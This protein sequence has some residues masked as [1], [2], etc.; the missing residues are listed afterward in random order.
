MR[1]AVLASGR[2]SNLEALLRHARSGLLEAGVGLLVTDRPGAPCVQ[3]AREGGVPAVVELPPGKD[4]AAY[5][6][7]LAAV[8]LGDAPDLVVL[9]GFMRILGPRVLG[10]FPHKIVNVHPS[11]LPAFKGANAVRSALR[12]GARVTGCTTHF[13]TADL[14]GGPGIL[15]AAVAVRPEDDED[16]LRS[17]IQALEH[18]VLPRTVQLAAEGRLRVEDGRVHVA[19]GPS[20][21][22]RVEPVAGAL[23]PDGF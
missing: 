19:P 4:A 7:A 16:S 18:Q 14:D 1:V 21:H 11:L 20:W 13:V 6:E 3:V 15:Q 2:G 17:Q 8:L 22:G 5:D 10:A 23:Y 9:A 12:H